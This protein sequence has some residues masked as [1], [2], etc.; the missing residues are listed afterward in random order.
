MIRAKVRN[1]LACS[2]T[3][4]ELGSFLALFFQQHAIST[5][6]DKRSREG[7]RLQKDKESTMF[8]FDNM[9]IISKNDFCH[10]CNTLQIV[11]GISKIF[12]CVKF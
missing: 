1:F 12:F 8:Y 4:C 2:C 3:Y 5:H 11:V 10:L 6:F 7:R 9:A